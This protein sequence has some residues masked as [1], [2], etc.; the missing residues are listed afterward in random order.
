MNRLHFLRAKGYLKRELMKQERRLKALQS[1]TRDL[2]ETCRLSFAEE[3]YQQNY[4]V[5]QSKSHISDLHFEQFPHALDLAMLEDEFENSVFWFWWPLETMHWIKKV[6]VADSL[7]DLKTSQSIRGHRFSNFAKFE[8]DTR[9]DEIF[10]YHQD[11]IGWYSGMCVR[12]AEAGW[13][14]K[15]SGDS[16]RCATVGLCIAGRWA[17]GIFSDFTEGPKHLGTN[18]TSMIHKS[19]AAS[20]KHTRKQRSIAD[21]ITSQTSSSA[22]PPRCEIWGEISGVD[23]KTRAMRPRR[24]VETCLEY[25]QAQRK[26]QSCI[27][28]AFRWVEFAGRIFTV[29]PERKWV[30]GGLRSKPAY[31]QQERPELCQIGTPEGVQKSD[32]D[33]NSQR[34]AANKR[35]DNSGCQRIGFIRDGDASSKIH[36]QFTRKVLRRSRV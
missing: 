8:F 23:I 1:L 26:G 17:A 24:C 13:R 21:K 25:L 15:C 11:S 7:F 27:L 14:Q 36:R 4:M 28:F 34:R 35:K 20:S 29:K 6:E 16:E 22:Q 5:G 9:W 10:V 30:C 12:K 19:C 32:E 3:V 33:G 18:S 2:P 31:D